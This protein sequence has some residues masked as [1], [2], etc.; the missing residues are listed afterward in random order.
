MNLRMICMSLVELYTPRN[1]TNRFH[2]FPAVS[3]CR[4]MS[5]LQLLLFQTSTMQA[6]ARI[7][8]YAIILYDRRCFQGKVGYRVNTS[9]LAA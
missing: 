6:W 5:R 9:D 8:H 2:V 4:I 3:A 1:L 7:Q